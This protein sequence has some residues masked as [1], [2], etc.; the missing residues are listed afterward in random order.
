M[1][2]TGSTADEDESLASDQSCFFKIFPDWALTTVLVADIRTWLSGRSIKTGFFFPENADQPDY[3]DPQHPRYAPKLAAT[4]RAWLA[5]EDPMGK[6]PK[7]ALMKW[8]RVHGAEYGLLDDEG[9][10]N[11]QG[12]EECAKVANWQPGGGAAKTPGG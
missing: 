1:T 6:H 2:V 5:V 8:L 4:V 12:I 10:P 3:L 7:Q 11:E 9:K